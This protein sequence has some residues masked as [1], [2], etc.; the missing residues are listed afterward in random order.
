M[1]CDTTFR[2][3]NTGEWFR[4]A[5]GTDLRVKLNHDKCLDVDSCEID[6]MCLDDI[7]VR[8]DGEITWHDQV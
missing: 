5:D 1:S 3:L 6:T 4:L 8:V 2:N 7:V